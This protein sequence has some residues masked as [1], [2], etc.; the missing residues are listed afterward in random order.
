LKEKLEIFYTNVEDVEGDMRRTHMKQKDKEELCVEAQVKLIKSL[1]SVIAAQEEVVSLEVKLDKLLESMVDFVIA[2]YNSEDELKLINDVVK[3]LKD[4]I[5]VVGVKVKDLKAN[6]II[7]ENDLWRAT[8]RLMVT[9]DNSNILEEVATKH[10]I[11]YEMVSQQLK[12]AK[13]RIHLIQI[14]LQRMEK[15]WGL[16][17]YPLPSVDNLEVVKNLDYNLNVCLVC[18]FWY[19]CHDHMT[20]PC[21]HTY[22]P[23]CMLQHS[24]HGDLKCLL[25]SCKVEFSLEWGATWG[26]QPVIQDVPSESI[27]VGKGGNKGAT[28]CSLKPKNSGK[29]FLGFW[30]IFVRSSLNH[31]MFLY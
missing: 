19:K 30:L 4:Q 7:A 1:A 28:R 13:S 27:G 21:G 11:K 12:V 3:D 2:R 10:K 6:K 22:H 24:V 18:G 14:Q 25:P 5:V 17:L 8:E 15:R 23:W 31:G 16:S 20:T 29:C 9:K 26:I